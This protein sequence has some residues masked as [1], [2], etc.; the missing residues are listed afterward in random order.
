[1]TDAIV[2]PSLFTGETTQDPA[3]WPRR[4]TN[5]YCSVQTNV[6]YCRESA[7]RLATIPALLVK[8]ALNSSKD[9]LM[10][11]MDAVTTVEDVAFACFEVTQKFPHLYFLQASI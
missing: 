2:S 9:A 6:W 4:F 8:S 1:M 10:P 5:S 7:A 11:I 3:T